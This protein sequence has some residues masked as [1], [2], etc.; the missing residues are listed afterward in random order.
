MVPN[1][2]NKDC[3]GC[4]KTFKVDHYVNPKRK[5]CSKPCYSNYMR[6]ADEPLKNRKSIFKRILSWINSLAAAL[7]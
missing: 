1:I 3:R 6:K 2:T 4:T 5:F 7:D